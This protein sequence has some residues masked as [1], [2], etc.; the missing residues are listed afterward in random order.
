MKALP[1]MIAL[2]LFLSPVY[3]QKVKVA[4]VGDFPFWASKKQPHVKPYVPGLNAVLLLTKE[5]TE[6]IGQAK[7]ETLG[8][9]SVKEA[10]KAGKTD[11]KAREVI[12]AAQ[13]QLYEKVNGILTGAQKELIEK[14]NAAYGDAQAAAVEAKQADFA[15]AKGNKEEMAKIRAAIEEKA[16]ADFSSK[17]TSL[18]S[19]EQQDALQKAAD[20]A[21]KRAADSPKKPKK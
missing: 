9:D 2:F 18:L 8:S 1:G 3:A 7:D 11:P 6:K 10:M 5:Q 4:Y 12:E 14:V 16:A 21:K 13:K 15:S 19:K 20:E 17:L